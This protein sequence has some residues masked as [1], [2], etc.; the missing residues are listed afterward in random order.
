MSISLLWIIGYFLSG[1]AVTFT[2]NPLTGTFGLTI[3]NIISYGLVGIALEFIRFRLLLMSGRRRPVLKGAVIATVLVIFQ[4]TTISFYLPDSLAVMNLLGATLLPLVVY[5]IVQ[6]YLAYTA[7]FNSMLVYATAWLI[8]YTFLPIMPKY[9]WYMVGMSALG[10]GMLIIILL[11]HAQQYDSH[12]PHRRRGSHRK[13]WL[14]E[15]ILTICMV[16]LIL[17]MTGLFSYKPIAIMSNS[18][19]PVYG[20]GDMVIAERRSPSTVI[21]VGDIIQYDK[22]GRHITHR[23]I[24]IAE[25]ENVV[26][27]ITK[28]DNNDSN[29]PWMVSVDQIGGIVR[30]KIPFIGYPTVILN[31]ILQGKK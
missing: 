1:V 8:L 10:F 13:N 18:M 29:D 11:D 2:H 5:H 24:A 20:R 12:A 17:F 9:D 30:A 25:D 6:T 15:G 4:M 21:Q 23:V 16:A 27:Y 19:H 22:D 7:G 28:G 26:Q 31:E 14:V 3:I